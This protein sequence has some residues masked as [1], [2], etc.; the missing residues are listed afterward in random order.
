M[1]DHKV[2][3]VTT[4][5]SEGIS[6]GDI[7]NENTADKG[8]G[9][10]DHGRP[11]YGE[12]GYGGLGPREPGHREPGH[13]EPGHREPGHREPGHR[14][15]GHREPGHREPGHREPG[16]T[17]GAEG[18]R[19]TSTHLRVLVAASGWSALAATAVPGPS[20]LRWIPVLLFVLFGPGCAALYP[21]PGRLASGARLEAVALAA[22]ISLSLGVLTATSL[23]LV[24]AFS[25]TAFL[26]SLACLTSVT[27][28]L[29]GLP[30][31]A[32]RRGAVER[33]KVRRRPSGG[34]DT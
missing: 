22:P 17:K 21:Q 19:F 26:V 6:N 34:S 4:T 15:P 3:E 20:P 10:L 23:F 27:A 30:L 25:M 7:N 9:D 16:H 33:A 1:N 32:A 8:H 31:P 14:E 28:A 12:P 2:I 18:G 24:K 13:R 11:G 5:D 29:P